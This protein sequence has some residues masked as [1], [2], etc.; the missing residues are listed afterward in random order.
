MP[1]RPRRRR[2]PAAGPCWF[3]R[4][5]QLVNTRV[6]FGTPLPA[7]PR[8]IV[9]PGG[10]RDPDLRPPH[11]PTHRQP[12]PQRAGARTRPPAAP[13]Q[14]RHRLRALGDPGDRRAAA[15]A[16]GVDRGGARS[17][18]QHRRAQPRSGEVAGLEGDTGHRRA[19]CVGAGGLRRFQNAR[20]RRTL[21]FLARST[22]YGWTYVVGIPVSALSNHASTA[23]SQ[24]FAAAGILLIIGLGLALY[25]ARSIAGPVLALKDAADELGREA[26][27]SAMHTGSERS[28]RGRRRAE[29]GRATLGRR[30]PD[31]RTQ[32][33]RGRAR[34]RDRA[35]P[36][37]RRS[38]ARGDRTFD[39]RPGARLQQ[40][41]ADDQHGTERAGASSRPTRWAGACWTPAAAR[42]ARRPSWCARC[43]PSAAASRSSRRRSTWATSCF[44]ARN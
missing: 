16:E 35:G 11:R 3:R 21:A 28:R 29:R 1:R 12:H 40:P 19:G 4:P 20:W 36:A 31:A 44:A 32:G 30:D 25:V 43:C 34:G 8:G 10:Q 38:E 26:V 2:A 24:A 6:P 14:R 15:A 13:L 7:P 41:A 27:P 39:R 18:A 17:L 5:R 22:R 37:A 23:T 33:R 42:R 9:A